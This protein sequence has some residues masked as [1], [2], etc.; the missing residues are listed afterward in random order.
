MLPRQPHIKIERPGDESIRLPSSSDAAIP[1]TSSALSALKPARK[2][3]V[4]G[5]SRCDSVRGIQE[6]SGM[7]GGKKC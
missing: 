1:L 6:G 4:V 5:K 2:R 7:L 3:K